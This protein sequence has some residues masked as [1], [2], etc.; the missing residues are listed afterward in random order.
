[1]LYKRWLNS[2]CRCVQLNE[3][4]GES[5][6]EGGGDFQRCCAYQ[7][8]FEFP[9][10]YDENTAFNRESY[11]VSICHIIIYVCLY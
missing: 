11:Y 4:V 2:Y 1:M 7:N 8:D 6:S 5:V 3:S 10:I 9:D